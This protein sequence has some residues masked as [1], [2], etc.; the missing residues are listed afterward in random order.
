MGVQSLPMSALSTWGPSGRPPRHRAT[1]PPR[2]HA[3]TPLTRA[4]CAFLRAQAAV[5]AHS[6]SADT[7][8]TRNLVDALKPVVRA[9]HRFPNV[10]SPRHALQVLTANLGS[11]R[12][13]LDAG[14]DI[15]WLPLQLQFDKDEKEKL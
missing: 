10:P 3:T 14:A 5:L 8:A 2:H 6:T 15:S 9:I 1:T 7:Q 13:A 12:E 4:P 11:T